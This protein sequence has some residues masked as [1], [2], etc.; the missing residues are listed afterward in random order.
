MDCI[1]YVLCYGYNI[2]SGWTSGRVWARD[3]DHWTYLWKLGF[4]IE[5]SWSLDKTWSHPASTFSEV[6]FFEAWW[7]ACSEFILQYNS[8][9]CNTPEDR[10]VLSTPRGISYMYAINELSDMNSDLL[11]MFWYANMSEIGCVFLRPPYEFWGC[12][13]VWAG[14]F[15]ISTT[16]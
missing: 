15:W 3:N 16:P 4:W 14:L 10:R 12:H 2:Y 1:T 5:F 7:F 8:V 6:I 13:I 11:G 9:W